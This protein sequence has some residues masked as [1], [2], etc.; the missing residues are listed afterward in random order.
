M[1]TP[2]PTPKV[3]LV[4]APTGFAEVVEG[5]H[6]DQRGSRLEAEVVDREPEEQIHRYM[7]LVTRLHADNATHERQIEEVRIAAT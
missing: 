7:R 3:C 4:P 2:T 1:C 5:L 6:G